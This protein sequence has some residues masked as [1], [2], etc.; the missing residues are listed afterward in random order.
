VRAALPHLVAA[1]A[2]DVLAVASEA[3]RRGFAGEAVYCATKFG[4]VGL[5]R[6]LDRELR[7]QSVRCTSVCPGG[8]ATDF[9]MGNGRVPGM[10]ELD[11]MLRAE[12]VANVIVFILQQPHSSRLLEV[13][14]RGP[15]EAS[16]G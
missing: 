15:G 12:D 8:V 16:A 4:Q 5:M 10:P 14:F 9:A 7:D 11:G 6:A 2:G 3:G 13:A 1:G